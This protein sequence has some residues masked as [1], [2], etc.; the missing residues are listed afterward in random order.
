MTTEDPG[1]DREDWARSRTYGFL[2]SLFVSAP[3]AE[4]LASISN[5]EPPSGEGPVGD[6]WV[7]LARAAAAADPE[8]VD[9]EF[10]DLFIGLGRGELLPYASWYLDGFL[11]G[12]PLVRLRSD[13]AALGFERADGVHEPEDHIAALFDVMAAL[14][15]P[16]QG[17]ALPGQQQFFANHI[18]PWVERFMSDLRTAQAAGFYRAVGQLGERFM[19]LE[20]QYLGIAGAAAAAEA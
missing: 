14:T 18:A 15:D 20:K 5:A 19:V 13:L 2:A 7:E 6:A 17:E 10:H 4:R 9:G 1:V 8:H 3:D 12:R 11:F 16:G